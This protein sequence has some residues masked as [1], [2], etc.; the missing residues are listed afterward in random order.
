MTAALN[1]FH[2]TDLPGDPCERIAL[3]LNSPAYDAQ[4]WA[5]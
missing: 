5:D 1:R 4:Y 2:L 3:L